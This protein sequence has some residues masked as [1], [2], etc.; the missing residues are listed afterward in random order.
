M[1]DAATAEISR[2]QLWQWIRNPG[3]RLESGR[4]IEMVMYRS[5]RAQIADEL[6]GRAGSGAMVNL[7]KA[8]ELLDELVLNDEFAAFLTLKAYESIS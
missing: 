4:K 8:A 2:A 1:E 3:A 6:I 5:A 7:V